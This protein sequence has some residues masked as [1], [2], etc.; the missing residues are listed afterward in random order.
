LAGQPCVQ[1][2]PQES[3]LSFTRSSCA[4]ANA[5]RVDRE[6]LLPASA[7]ESLAETGIAPR[8]LALKGLLG[9]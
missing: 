3:L 4:L 7:L 5:S 6:T 9:E 2:D 8:F 1:N